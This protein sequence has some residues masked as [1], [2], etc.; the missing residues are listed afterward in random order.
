MTIGSDIAI[1]N[2]T[3]KRCL[4]QGGKN[5]TIHELLRD[6]SLP[7]DRFQIALLHAAEDGFV[8]IDSSKGIV[9]EGPKLT[10]QPVP[11][12]LEMSP[13]LLSFV[14]TKQ[15]LWER[16]FLALL[17]VAFV[18]LLSF[19]ISKDKQLVDQ[20]WRLVRL[21]G[22]L[23]AAGVGAFLTGMVEVK[24]ERGGL[25]VRATGAFACFVIVFWFL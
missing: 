23:L 1:I 4:V 18:G 7:E 20:A 8:I 24:G 19:Q 10:N 5:P 15:P 25:A 2:R 17:V 21:F 12:G 14:P 9:G 16:I 13:R 22:S 11:E 3:L 6:S